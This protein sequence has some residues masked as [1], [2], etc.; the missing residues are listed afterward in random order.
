[1]KNKGSYLSRIL[2]LITV[3]SLL[4]LSCGSAFAAPEVTTAEMK[5]QYLVDESPVKGVSFDIYKI[6][7]FQGGVTFTWTEEFSKYGITIPDFLSAEE[8]STFTNTL[9]GYIQ[10]D[11]LN[12][13]K[14]GVTDDSGSF[15]FKNLELGMYIVVGQRYETQTHIYEPVPFIVFFP[16]AT[17]EGIPAYSTEVLVKP[18]MV[19]QLPKVDRHVL[20]VWD[21]STTSSRPDSISVQLLKD[22]E[23]YE[24]IEL[25]AENNWRHSWKD[26]DGRHEWR[27]I[28]KDKVSGYT[29]SSKEEGLTYVITNK[30]NTPPPPSTYTPPPTPTRP[31]PFASVEVPSITIPEG[32]PILAEYPNLPEEPP[33][34]PEPEPEIVPE[35]PVPKDPVI[36]KTGQLSWPIPV[37]TCMGLVSLGGGMIGTKKEDDDKEE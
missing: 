20:K 7:D 28:E 21:D 16:H 18:R 29:T 5:G 37:M 19:E 23:V 11:K 14:H 27:C 17:E 26:L 3:I 22:G 30:R 4:L 25:S 6:A 15:E 2:S 34:E 12:S 36:P 32:V 24:T 31:T 8:S 9:V 1:M 35:Q 10:R 13:I 33:A